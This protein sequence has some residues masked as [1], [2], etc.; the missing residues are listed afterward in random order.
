MIVICDTSPLNYLVLID[1][2]EVVPKLMPGVV[3]PPEVLSEL[4]RAGASEPVRR[5]AGAPPAW[6]QVRSPGRIEPGLELHAGE[7]A[8]ISLALELRAASAV[9]LLIDERMGRKVAQRYGLSTLGTLAVLRDGARAGYFEID[10]AIARLRRTRF[11]ATDELYE[12]L[13]QSVRR[14]ASQ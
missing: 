11:R 12:Q 14:G 3:A 2:I 7:T 10:D 1:L 5:W 8:A 4:Q 13:R 9:Q 6:L